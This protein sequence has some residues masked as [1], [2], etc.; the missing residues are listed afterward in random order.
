M[1]VPAVEAVA[2]AAGIRAPLQPAALLELSQQTY[3]RTR[4]LLETARLI[5]R[6]CHSD[7][8]TSAH[9]NDA[10]RVHN[11]PVSQPSCAPC[12]LCS[13]VVLSSPYVPRSSVHTPG[14]GDAC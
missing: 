4:Q 10:L 11:L 12:F 2:R 6:R 8:L 7:R 3:E 14:R 9:V 13:D 5:M 1:D